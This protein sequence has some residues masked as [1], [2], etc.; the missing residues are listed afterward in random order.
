MFDSATAALFDLDVAIRDQ[1][2]CCSSITSNEDNWHPFMMGLGLDVS[3]DGWWGQSWYRSICHTFRRFRE[4][5][6][7]LSFVLCASLCCLFL[8]GE[9]GIFV[10]QSALGGSIENCWFPGCV[11]D[12]K[13]LQG[14]FQVVF[15]V[16]LLT[17]M[18]AL[19]CG[20][21]PEEQLLWDMVVWHPN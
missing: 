5:L 18:M 1:V 13:C 14:N 2:C 12:I 15:E 9:L 6:W 4:W 16:L 19:A 11:V 8:F 7:V 21:F 10:Y 17:T 3:E 20:L